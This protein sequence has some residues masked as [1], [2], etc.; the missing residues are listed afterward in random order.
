MLYNYLRFKKKLFCNPRCG[1][2]HLD[3]LSLYLVN[4]R[5]S[6]NIREDNWNS[7]PA[8]LIDSV[9]LTR[10]PANVGSVL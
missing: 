7:L 2:L 6:F 3:K 5:K 9:H 8:S 4:A 1:R 10:F